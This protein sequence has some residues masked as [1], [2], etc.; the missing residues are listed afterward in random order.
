MADSHREGTKPPSDHFFVHM[1]DIV[2]GEICGKWGC[3]RERRQQ[4][5]RRMLLQYHYL[6]RAVAVDL[7]VGR[8]RGCRNPSA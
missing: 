6:S 4:E 8:P 1:A 2:D 5:V 3:T 7:G